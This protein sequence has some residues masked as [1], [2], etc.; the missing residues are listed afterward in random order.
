[1]QRRRITPQFSLCVAPCDTRI[2]PNSMG[3]SGITE[4]DKPLIQYGEKPGPLRA[5]ATLQCQM[6]AFQ[7]HRQPPTDSGLLAF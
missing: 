6:A 3:F 7:R 5:A 4:T 2:C 1:M